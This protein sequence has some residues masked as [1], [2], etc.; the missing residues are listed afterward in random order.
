MRDLLEIDRPDQLKALGHPLRLRV[1]ET[2]GA[3]EDDELTNRELANRLGVDPGHLHFHVRMLLNA[4]LIELAERSGGREKPY[5]A[6]ARHVRVAPELIATGAAN[7][8]REA[9]LDQVR[10]GWSEFA[11]SGSFRS[12]QLNIRLDQQEV[13]DLFAEF[14]QRAAELEDESKEPLMVTFF[15]HPPPAASEMA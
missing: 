13:R 3:D 14:V 1:L 7:D 8:A 6:V 10:R 9:M 2:L 11:S 12:A 15:S 5:R 4:G